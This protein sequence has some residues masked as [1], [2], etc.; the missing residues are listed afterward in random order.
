MPVVYDKACRRSPC[1]LRH[2]IRC[3]IGFLAVA[4]IGGCAKPPPQATAVRSYAFWPAPPDEPRIQFLTTIN[5]SAD[6]APR[7][8]GFDELVYGKDQDQVLSVAKPYG[9]AMWNGRI[10]VCDVRGGGGIIVLD[11]RKQQTRVMGLAGSITVKDPADVAVAEDGTKYVVDQAQSAVIV[12]DANERGLSLFALRDARPISVAVYKDLLYVADTKSQRI[13]VL[14]RR[15]GRELR[16]IG[17][18]G[19]A[20]GQFVKPLKVVADKSGNIYVSD[21]LKSRVQKFSPD[22]QLLL[23]FGQPGDR[24]GDLGRPK[25]LGVASDG[26]VY[27]TDALFYNVQMFDEEGKVIMFFGSGGDHP[28]SMDLPAGLAVHEGDLDLFASYIHPAFQ[29]ERLIV[30][31]NQFGKNKVAVYAMGHLKPGKTLS[32]ITNRA[33]VS[34]GV[35]PTTQPATNPATNP[36]VPPGR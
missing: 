27:V 18:P 28:G 30:V 31:T 5:T 13:L 1:R 25:H 24:P 26:I 35:D 32:D 19:G 10:Y 4:L 22:G 20:D 33:D 15:T 29:A 6:V 16:T 2:G 14:D 23:A 21:V 3:L 8:S 11:L 17:E 12:F 34:A 36:P 9:V 7:K